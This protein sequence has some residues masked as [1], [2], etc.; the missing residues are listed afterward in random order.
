[1]AKLIR[2]K[3]LF[4]S[5]EQQEGDVEKFIIRG[6]FSTDDLDRHD[7]KVIQAGWKLEEFLANPV[8]LFAHDNYTPAVGK[9]TELSIDLN[10]S[11]SGAIQFAVNEDTSGLAKTLYNLYAG[12]FMRAFSVGFR[13]D[14]YEVDQ[15]NN[16][17]VLKE[18][19]LF[20]IS[21][22]NV[23]ANA[24]ALAES[25]GIDVKSLD[26]LEAQ[27]KIESEKIVVSV[28]EKLASDV[29]AEVELKIKNVSSDTR[30]E[31]I[32]VETPQAT[33]GKYDCRKINK[34]I[35]QL[36]NKKKKIKN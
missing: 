11:L 12:G 36:L 1:M 4:K 33:G 20:E 31:K 25:K 6:I 15:E 21:C 17:V 5:A 7:E 34:A 13:N 2:K 9:A 23:P 16:I 24:M 35:R 14:V 32:K 22:V 18:N 30:K 27:E 3:F 28:M 10:G 29:L 26:D 19:T 8:I